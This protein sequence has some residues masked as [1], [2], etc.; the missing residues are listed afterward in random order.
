MPGASALSRCDLGFVGAGQ[1]ARMGCEAASALGLRV[2]VLAERPDDA[3]CAAAAEVV[4]GSPFVAG[5][6][7]ALAARCPV[8]TFDHEQVDLDLVAALARTGTAVH[9]GAAALELAVDKARMRA[10]L[11]Q[12][13]VPVPAHIVIDSGPAG[14]LDPHAA[15]AVDA[16]AGAH[17][18]PLVL[19]AARGGYDGKGVWPVGGLAEAER[20]LAGIGGRPSRRCTSRSR[21]SSR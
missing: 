6:L 4:V 20:V 5:D 2:A 14:H 9:P 21:P 18:W 3:A 10:V 12:A 17:G 19:K 13:G 8:V 11:D 7:D 16:F 15:G 1:L